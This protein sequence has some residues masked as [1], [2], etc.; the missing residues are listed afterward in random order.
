MEVEQEREDERNEV[1]RR[2][3]ENGFEYVRVAK[4]G[5]GSGGGSYSSNRWVGSVRDE[6]VV[7]YFEGFYVD[8][9]RLSFSLSLE[10]VFY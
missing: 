6:E 3:F 8:K 1:L 5:G 7:S 4:E 10:V 2:V 9:V